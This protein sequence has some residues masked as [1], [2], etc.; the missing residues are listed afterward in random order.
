MSRE[1]HENSESKDVKESHKE[2]ES[3]TADEKEKVQSASDKIRN[4]WYD[5]KDDSDKKLEKIKGEY[6]NDLKKNSECPETIKNNAFEVSDLKKRTPEETKAMRQEFNSKKDGL[7][8]EWEAKNGR[9]WPRYEHDVVN[10]DG[11]VIK[12][13]GYKYDAHHIQPLSLGGENTADNITPLK[14]EVHS[15]HKGVHAKDSPYNQM[16]KEVKE[17]DNK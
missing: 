4:S 6:I 3:Y 2:T 8:K 1:I 13:K 7:I 14:S 9:E 11:K 10:E 15:D 16:E 12:K 17:R 5:S